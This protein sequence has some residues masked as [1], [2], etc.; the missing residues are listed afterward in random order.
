MLHQRLHLD[1]DQITPFVRDVVLPCIE[2]EDPVVSPGAS[3]FAIAMR[4]STI[5]R[6][7]VF[8]EERIPAHRKVIEY[9]G[10]WIDP[11]EAKRRWARPRAYLFRYNE[12]WIVDG[13]VGGNGSQYINHSC[14]PNIKVRRLGRHILYFSKRVIE[15]GEELTV[16]YEFSPESTRVDCYCGSAKCRGTINVLPRK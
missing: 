1:P 13:A 3:R 15:A 16:D 9:A 10:Q 5:H 4:F 7:G 11:I 12:H 8:A 6:W 14:E 2:F